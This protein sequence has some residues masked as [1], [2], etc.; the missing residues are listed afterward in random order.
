MLNEFDGYVCVLTSV[1]WMSWHCIG[2]INLSCL[3]L[4]SDTD[5]SSSWL[6]GLMVGH[7]NSHM[8]CRGLIFY[9]VFII[10]SKLN[11]IMVSPYSSGQIYILCSTLQ[12]YPPPP[13]SRLWL[14]LTE[15]V[16]YIQDPRHAVLTT[17]NIF[18]NWRWCPRW[19]PAYS[20]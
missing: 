15:E 10:H 8:K 12:K 17:M 14:I 11:E 7:T 2:W 1:C 13:P 19:P 18:V 5:K 3:V 4:S 6:V 9:K 20:K 16:L